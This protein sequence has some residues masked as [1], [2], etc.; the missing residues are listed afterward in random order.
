MEKELRE[1]IARV[2]AQCALLD[3]VLDGLR[4]VL[5]AESADVY[6]VAQADLLSCGV[7]KLEQ[8]VRDLRALVARLAGG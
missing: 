5:G 1:S 2:A 6:L 8:R 3:A 4:D 7:D